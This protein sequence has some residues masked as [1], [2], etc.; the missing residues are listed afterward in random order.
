METPKLT[1]EIGKKFL[2]FWVIRLIGRGG[3][4]EVYEIRHK[5]EPQALK[6]IQA[7]WLGEEILM[8]RTVDEGELLVGIKHPNVVAVHETGITLEGQVWIRM[9]LLR[10]ETLREVM[11][12]RE[13]ISVA[14]ACTYMRSVGHAAHQCHVIGAVHRDIKPENLFITNPDET[15]KLLDFGI[16]KLYGSP[17]TGDGQRHG[18]PL[19]MAPEQIRG[20]R[21]TPATDVYA[22]GLVAYELLC[23]ANPFVDDP[24][25]YDLYAL[26]WKHFSEVPAPLT[27]IGIPKEIS[28]VVAKALAK[29]PK[30]RH[31]SG[32]EFAEALWGAWCIVREREPDWDTEPGE[33]TREELLERPEDGLS[34]GTGPS[35]GRRP[36]A[37]AE[38]R[39]SRTS[40]PSRISLVHRAVASAKTEPLPKLPR[41]PEALAVFLAERG[42]NAPPAPRADP[43]EPPGHARNTSP[44]GTSARVYAPAAPS[45]RLAPVVELGSPCTLG[46]VQTTVPLSVG[47]RRG[48]RP[49][50]GG[51]GSSRARAAAPTRAPSRD[52]AVVRRGHGAVSR[53]PAPRRA[54]PACTR[55]LR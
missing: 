36:S 5:G 52:P 43:A 11:N 38:G 44:A 27:Q 16:A 41:E 3:M 45:V 15:V 34:F 13:L 2:S 51:G 24:R 33:P 48:R 53:R 49:G 22:L 8:R 54:T 21:V 14:L 26:Y 17:D 28:D 10:G 50:P 20:H 4:G 12:R 37:P 46:P 1:L 6:V 7:K 19:Y 31:Q 29:D 47:P 32:H 25:A 18:T 40:R 23:G 42:S 9:E 55:T 30:E 39:P 35:E